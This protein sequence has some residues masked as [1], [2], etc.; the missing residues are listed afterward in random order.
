M[1]REEI[2][3]EFWSDDNTRR[4]EVVNVGATERR[5]G[6][7]MVRFYFN[8]KCVGVN[9]NDDTDYLER[10]AEDYVLGHYNP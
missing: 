4:A 7:D 3:S 1:E 8:E 9:V 2:L 10:L 6:T 5:W